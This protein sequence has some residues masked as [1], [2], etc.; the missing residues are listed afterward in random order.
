MPRNLRTTRPSP[1]DDNG[2]RPLISSRPVQYMRPLLLGRR[3]TASALGCCIRSVDNL[4]SS[5]QLVTRKIGSRV[6]VTA[7]SLERFASGE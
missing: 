2:N 5:G 1:L 4:I 3:Q 6:L 7:A